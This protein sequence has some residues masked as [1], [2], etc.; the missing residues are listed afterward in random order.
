[1]QSESR[2][3]VNLSR[4]VSEGRDKLCH[5]T[6]RVPR[7]R[8]GVETVFVLRRRGY[9]VLNPALA[10]SYSSSMACFLFFVITFF[11][12]SGASGQT[13]VW[14]EESGLRWFVVSQAT[15]AT[16]R[17]EIAGWKLSRPKK[18]HTFTFWRDS[19]A[20]LGCFV[21]VWAN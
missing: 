10:V 6:K 13:G 20:E 21:T 11:H 1:M 3:R 16:C 19:L 8:G 18:F 17:V 4:P 15:V 2:A 5:M 12:S 7:H 9:E 14:D